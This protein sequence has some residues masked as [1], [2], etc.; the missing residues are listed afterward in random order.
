[1]FWNRRPFLL[2]NETVRRKSLLYFFRHRYNLLYD[3]LLKLFVLI[4]FLELFSVFT[5]RI[6]I[7]YMKNV[8]NK[9][10]CFIRN[11]ET[12]ALIL[13]RIV[14]DELNTNYSASPRQPSSGP[15]IGPPAYKL[16]TEA[17]IFHEFQL[18][19]IR[20][21]NKEI[22][23]ITFISTLICLTPQSSLKPSHL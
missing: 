6:T 2:K 9:P 13:Y 7:F 3:I 17:L 1:M 10:I 23:T 5:H 21:K 19:E 16:R 11:M 15:S 18:F 20:E 22:N 4:W 12:W 8:L 14:N